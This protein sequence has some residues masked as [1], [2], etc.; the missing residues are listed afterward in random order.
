MRM[1]EI[2]AAGWSDANHELTGRPG[3]SAVRERAPFQ[4]KHYEKFVT[5][6]KGVMKL[7]EIRI[8]TFN[9]ENLLRRFDFYRYGNLT[10]ER[11]LEILGVSGSSEEGMLLRKS[12][13][14]A[15]TDDTR[16]MTAQAISDTRADVVCL[17]EVENIEVL[18]AF[19]TYYL[20]RAAHAHYGWLRLLEGNDRRGIDV[21]VMSR[22]RITVT[23]HKD[24]TFDDFGLFNDKLREYGLRPG[25]SIFRR[26]CLE[27][28]LTVDHNPLAIFICHFKSMSGGRDKT[29]PVRQAEAEA[30]RHIIEE[31]YG[32]D[33]SGHDWLIAGDLNDYVDPNGESGVDPLFRDGFSVNVV[34]NLAATNQWTHYYPAE[35]S[36]HQ[37]DYL[38]LSP[39]LA[40]KN[41]N[42]RPAINRKGQP[43]R[44]PGLEQEDRYPRTGFDRPKASDHCP[45]AVTLTV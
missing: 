7:A 24:H 9:I 11:A 40:A 18:K 6:L 28:E 27:V 4:H 22:R 33:S 32:N 14:V 16:Q 38:L 8:A 1:L 17:Q 26:D 23:T 10:R 31:K 2:F 42:R 43:W 34:E 41:A 25:D 13:F 44:V 3:Q 35:R 37:L 21:A 29:M 20:D 45:V 15:L 36:F 19:E 30:V 5:R 12:L 39:S